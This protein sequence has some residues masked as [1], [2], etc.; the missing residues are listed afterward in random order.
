MSRTYLE[1]VQDFVSEEGVAG[2]TGPVDL[3]TGKES[4][5]I[6]R[7]IQYVRE[8]HLSICTAWPDWDFLWETEEGTTTATQVTAGDTLLPMANPVPRRYKTSLGAFQIKQGTS[9]NNIR[10]MWWDE[11]K[12]SQRTGSVKPAKTRPAFWTVR[13]DK[14]IELS[15]PIGGVFDYRYEYFREPPSLVE[16][17]DEIIL[18]HGYDRLVLVRAKIIFAERE[19]APEI[20]QGSAAEFDDLMTRLEANFLPGFRGGDSHEDQDLVVRDV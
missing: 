19:N 15:H 2:G 8:A 3:A 12:R 4:T 7:V 17:G 14:K 5:G 10:H 18:P 9:W 6:A 13:P 16:D 11:F 1:I 20:M